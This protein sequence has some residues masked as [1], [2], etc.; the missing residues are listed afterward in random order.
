MELKGSFKIPFSSIKKSSV[1]NRE[2]IQMEKQV[3]IIGNLISY[4]AFCC[5]GFF[6]V[7][8]SSS[9]RAES[10]LFPLILSY[11]LILFNFYLMVNSI[12]GWFSKK[13]KGNF[14]NEKKKIGSIITGRQSMSHEIYPFITVMLCIFFILG[15]ENIGF[16][17]SAFFL[18]FVTMILINPKE[19][20]RKFYI[21]LFIPF[22]LILLFKIGLNLRIPLFI[23]RFLG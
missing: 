19:G 22:L 3:N 17:I 16:D 2:K 1:I 21:A 8:L 5:L 23:E 20:F 15:F 14:L 9:I 10:A 11:L 13:N 6:I 12:L 7:Y 18:T 4:F